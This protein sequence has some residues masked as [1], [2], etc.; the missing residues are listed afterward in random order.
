MKNLYSPTGI[1]S[2]FYGA[3]THL[4]RISK[5]LWNDPL[6]EFGA[7]GVRSCRKGAALPSIKGK[8]PYYS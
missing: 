6:E 3:L 8:R 1:V 5:Q 4:Y 2:T 7:P